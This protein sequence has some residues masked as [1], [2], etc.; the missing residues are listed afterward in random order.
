MN[1]ILV[2]FGQ[3]LI[4]SLLVSVGKTQDMFVSEPEVRMQ[5]GGFLERMV[6]SDLPKETL[7]NFP[8]I[9]ESTVR[10][11]M[12]SDQAVWKSYESRVLQEMQGVLDL[13]FKQN[14][15]DVYRISRFD[16]TFSDPMVISTT[17]SG[18]G[19]VHALAHELAHRLL[20]DNTKN[21]PVSEILE[22]M[23]PGEPELTRNHIV[24][25]ATLTYIFTDVFSEPG[26]L[27]HERT[28]G[29]WEYQRAWQIVDERGY[30]EIITEFRS[31]Y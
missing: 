27:R 24:V 12:Q 10:K 11:S 5:Y 21:I 17:Y 25:F 16:E 3:V 13:A 14:I 30:R 20:T 1:T 19:F 28:P 26:M 8:S 18:K 9:D 31:H 15:I 23:F 22:N 29:T 4:L 7:R 6:E 2:R